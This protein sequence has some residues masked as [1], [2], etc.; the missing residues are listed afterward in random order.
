MADQSTPQ[1]PIRRRCS[2]WPLA[3]TLV[4]AL[5]GM[6]AQATPTAADS[7]HQSADPD[8]VQRPG[9][10]P[11]QAFS[12]LDAMLFPPAELE[13]FAPIDESAS[14]ETI[15]AELNQRVPKTYSYRP[16]FHDN[17]INSAIG[18]LGTIWWPAWLLWGIPEFARYRDH[19]HI[20]N[21]K[22]RVAY[23]RQLSAAK[24]CWV[25]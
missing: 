9:A 15:Y 25:K 12:D 14:C 10:G 20:V 13:A 19:R 2:A 7:P 3:A 4:G 16:K 21:N 24:Q 6:P 1:A 11:G 8:A 5:A 17:P 22:Q 18:T 23:L